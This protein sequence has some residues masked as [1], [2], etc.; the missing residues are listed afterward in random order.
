M[1]NMKS[2]FAI[3]FAML[4]LCASSALA[5]TQRLGANLPIQFNSASTLAKTAAYTV[6]TSDVNKTIS[7]TASSANIVITLPSIASANST[8]ASFPLKI[9][10]ADATTYSIIVTPATGDTVGGEST[11]YLI[12]QNAYMVIHAGQGKDWAVDYESPYVVEDHE[13]GSTDLGTQGYD[14]SIIFEGATADAYE[15][16]LAVVDPTADATWNIPAATAATTYYFMETA[17][18]TN[19]RDAANSVVG[20]SNGLKF[21]G[22]TADAYETTLTVTDPTADHTATLPDATGTLAMTTGLGSSASLFSTVTV[23]TTFTSADCGKTIGIA[24]A[25]LTMKLP[26]TVAG[27]IFRFVNTG[28]AT[29]NIMT[30]DPDNADNIWGTF[31]LAATVVVSEGAAGVTIVNTAASSVKGDSVTLIGDGVDGW[32]ILSSTGI[33]AEGS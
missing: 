24:T 19:Y 10:K 30:I 8:G 23:S 5:T 15:T 18:A 9:T 12:N 26:P 33:W 7:V 27:C 13:A 32:F 20:V 21:E 14:A 25:A 1:K 31:T 3:A 22:A 29:A 17:L 4:L 6:T 2:I 11:R 28:A 16:A